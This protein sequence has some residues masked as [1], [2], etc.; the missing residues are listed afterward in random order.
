MKWEDPSVTQ[1][2]YNSTKWRAEARTLRAN[3]GR[4]ALLAQT[5]GTNEARNLAWQIKTGRLQAFRP[6]GA[7]QSVSR[8]GS[9]YARFLPDH[10]RH[11]NDW[12]MNCPQCR[13]EIGQVLREEEEEDHEMPKLAALLAVKP[14]WEEE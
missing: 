14:I 6:A 5:E 13:A 7:F 8:A 4:W 2:A 12:D 10:T 9:V 1:R 11:G 3:P